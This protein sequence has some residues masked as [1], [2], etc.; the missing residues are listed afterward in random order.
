M[1]YLVLA[2]KSRP[3][4]FAQ[5]VGQ[6]AVV[7]TLQNG[8][9]QNRVP[10]ALIFSGVRG[11]GKTTLARIMAKA[12]NCEK[13]EPPEPCNECRSCK[14]IMAG[15][16]VDLHEV[17]GASNRGIQE[18]RELKENI[19]F[20]PTSSKFK[21]II[22]D[23][24]HMLTT[25]AFNALLKTLEEPPEHVYFMFATTELHKV[26]VTILS[27]C[28]RYELKRVSHAELSAHFASLAEQEGISIDES[29]LN[30]VV[31]EAGGSVRDG[32]SLLDQVFSYCGDNV[33]GEEVADVL[34]L[35]SHEVIADLARALLAKDIATALDC[36]EKVY[37]YGMDIKRFINELLAWFRNL[38]V[39]S[40]SKDPA[41]LLDLPADELALLQEVAGTH[42]SQ[43]LFMM[44]NLLLEGLEKAAFSPR[45]RFAV[46]MT[47]I[48]A[49]QVDD[50][51]PVTDLLT[52]L[53]DVLAGV[54]L[55]QQQVARQTMPSQ[56]SSQIP[57][58]VSQPGQGRG[59]IMPP[60]PSSS[61]AVPSA[62]VEKKKEPEPVIPPPQEPPPVEEQRP[63]EPD[64]PE[65]LVGATGRSPLPQDTGAPVSSGAHTKDVRKL[66][67]GFVQYVQER[68]QWMAAA[69]KSSSSV[70]LENGVLTVNYDD[71]ADCMLL[72][73]KENLVQLTEYAMDYFQEELEVTFKVPNS[74][75]CAT[76]SNGA[77]AVRQERKKLANDALVLA[78]VDIF[79]GQ[80]GDI[81][82][83]ARFRGTLNEEKNDE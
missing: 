66:W 38:V 1:S 69:L 18:I 65:K 78:A 76:D 4:T 45:P 82:V 12:L 77:A 9:V 17:D 11:T 21:I 81:R 70:R 10:H 50:V 42:S 75:A 2:R 27:R 16:S 57:Q 7:R 74:S 5:V 68:V 59:T 14:E 51:V 41:A 40:V 71:S 62:E 37:S 24:V 25:E 60:P 73:N 52:R 56:Q 61:Q 58:Q 67:P 3:Q 80:V 54:A 36:L 55:P 33:T 32:L 26:P 30:M 23:E 43:T 72:G 8:L 15:S 28:Q 19:R 53:D 79:S 49:V 64:P 39:C 47:F 35:V 46:E 44:F 63:P 48:R 31:R 34:G 83:G 29:A 13:G 6:K 22:I 20:M